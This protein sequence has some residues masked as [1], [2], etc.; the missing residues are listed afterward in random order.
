MQIFVIKQQILHLKRRE[1]Y[2][3]ERHAFLSD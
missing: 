2:K 1:Q 3:D